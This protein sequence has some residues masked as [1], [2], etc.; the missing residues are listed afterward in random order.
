M[1]NVRSTTFGIQFNVKDRNLKNANKQVDILKRNVAQSGVGLQNM[2]QSAI[3]AGQ[4]IVTGMKNGINSLHNFRY[5]LLGAFTAMSAAIG[6]SVKAAADFEYQIRTTGLVARAT[7]NEIDLLAENAKRLGIETVFTATE[8]AEGQEILARAGFETR[9]ILKTLPSVLDAAA[10]ENLELSRS[11]DIVTSI[12]RGMRM[13]VGESR[14]IIDTLANA[15]RRSKAT[16]DGLGESI[17]QVAAQAANLGFSIEELS[18]TFGLL[19]DQGTKASRAGRLMRGVIKSLTAPSNQGIKALDRLGVS[20]WE[21]EDT[22]KSIAGIVEEF[23]NAMVDMS[24]KEKQ[25]ALGE[26]FTGRRL[27]IF[28]QLM[29]AGSEEIRNFTSVLEESGGVAEYMAE[30]QLD[31]FMGAIHR[32]RGSINVAAISMQLQLLPVLSNVVDGITGAINVFNELPDV[33][34]S[35]I[36]GIGLVATGLLG[37]ATVAAFLKTPLS[38]LVGFFKWIGGTAIFQMLAGGISL[39]VGTALGLLA[40]VT[41]LYFAWEDM[42]LTMERG[43]DG[44]LVPLFDKFLD[45][46]GVGWDFKDVWQSGKEFFMDFLTSLG[47]FNEGFSEFSVGFAEFLLALATFDGEGIL[48]SFD[49]MHEGIKD[50]SLGFFDSAGA[51]GEALVDGIIFMLD[52]KGGLVYTMLTS[53]VERAWNDLAVEVA[54]WAGIELPEIEFP[55][56]EEMKDSATAWIPDFWNTMV[57]LWNS[58][59]LGFEE[60]FDLSGQIMDNVVPDWLKP[61]VPGFGGDN[62]SQNPYSGSGEENGATSYSSRVMGGEY[63]IASTN[64]TNQRST[65]QTNNFNINI[66]NAGGNDEDLVM[67]I[68]R[69]LQ[70]EFTKERIAEVGDY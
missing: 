4:N 53:L 19:A 44:V 64:T 6:G 35:V 18:A 54:S 40:V 52:L 27:L 26:I 70:D 20:L 21:D 55:T 39:T 10:I 62:T 38:M 47:Q 49:T 2:G 8:A 43:Y 28:Q 5:E 31:T 51:I 67:K 23:S 68:K 16:M 3:V 63:P 17:P 37:I 46:I 22:F 60:A 9:E 30:E 15:S 25:M 14:R 61:Y 50:M 69:T 11:A 34:Q 1:A 66:D 36:G 48:E 24:E 13:E 58:I 29:N 65:N 12:L 33:T 59:T 57:E 42:F 56:W 32:L 45:W 41:G 7:A